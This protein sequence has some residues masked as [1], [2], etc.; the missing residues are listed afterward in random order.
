MGKENSSGPMRA[1][2]KATSSR[3][4]FMA[5][6]STSGQM[7]ESTMASGS[8]T[9]WKVKEL[10]LGQTAGC[11]LV[12]TKTT[13]SMVTEPLSGQTV[14]STS[15]NGLKANNTEREF[16]SRKERRDR[17]SGRW[18]KELNGLRTNDLF[19]II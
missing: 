15:E 12:P 3:T 10:S 19:L 13:K 11:T 7:E 14:E 8:T 18:E 5:R 2:T 9:R 4:T 17:A 16:T 6:E 1:P